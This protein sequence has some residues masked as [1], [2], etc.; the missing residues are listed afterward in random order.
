[1]GDL[2]TNGAGPAARRSM[3]CGRKIRKGMATHLPQSARQF[4]D[5]LQNDSNMGKKVHGRKNTK[6]SRMRGGTA[7]SW[8][9]GL[10]PAPAA[11]H[12]AVNI[13]A[14]ARWGIFRLQ[15]HAGSRKILW[16][17]EKCRRADGACPVYAAMVSKSSLALL[18]AGFS[19]STASR[20]CRASS[21]RPR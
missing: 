1:M 18:L 12:A 4:N 17:G 14:P 2:L 21:L 5:C 16:G 6:T 9:S 20:C 11:A 10:L 7:C 3:C 19:P 15:A 13:S 8:F